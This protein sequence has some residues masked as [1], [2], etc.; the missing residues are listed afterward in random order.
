MSLPLYCRFK[1]STISYS[2]IAFAY[3]S[4]IFFYPSL[5]I[6]R[7]EECADLGFSLPIGIIILALLCLRAIIPISASNKPAV[8]RH[9]LSAV[10]LFLPFLLLNISSPLLLFLYL[11]PILFSYVI[12]EVYVRDRDVFLLLLRRIA[13]FLGVFSSLHVVSSVTLLG[14]FQAFALRGTCS[15]FNLFS[16]YQIY[17]Y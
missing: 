9:F 17:I 14:F 10:F 8:T 11:V 7:G 1:L 5:S 3:S 6:V 12:V 13:L 4:P 2:L 16:I 15:I